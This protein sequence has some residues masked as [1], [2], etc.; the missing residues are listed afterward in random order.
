MHVEDPVKLDVTEKL[1][2]LM[3]AFKAKTFALG[4][5]LPSTRLVEI[6]A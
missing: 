1:M 6:Y 5:E 4:E 2:S 3:V